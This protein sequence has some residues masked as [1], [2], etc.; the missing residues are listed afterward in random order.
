MKKRLFTTG[1][2]IFGGIAC[3]LILLIGAG[4]CYYWYK[5]S[6]A[7]YEKEAAQTAKP[8]SEWE[9]SQKVNT[10]NVTEEVNTTPAEKHNATTEKPIT[11]T[12]DVSDNVLQNA[13]TKNVEAENYVEAGTSPTETV[14]DVPVSP[15]GFG[16]YPKIP[17]GA[18]I[19]KFDDSDDIDMELLIRVAVKAWN[20]GERFESAFTDGNTGRVYLNYPGI[21]YVEYSEKRDTATGEVKL[22]VS[23][24]TGP[25][26]LS[27]S[28]ISSVFDGNT[29]AGYTTIDIKE[30]GIDPYEYLELP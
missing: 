21:V 24:V 10:N 19:A 8:V 15:H 13:N 23:N 16:P 2:L 30:S 7:P 14:E 12:I 22:V 17:K 9:K 1:E 5:H 28:V 29:P 26:S 27:Q 4:A 11:E 3:L 6:I 20:E 18:P 25:A